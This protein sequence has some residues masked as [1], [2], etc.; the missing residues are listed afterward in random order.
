MTNNSFN[1]IT[2]FPKSG[3]TWMRFIIYELFFNNENEN[4][5]NSL[6]IKKYIPDLHTL[7]IQNNKVVLNNELINKK[8][9]LKS[10][11]SYNQMKN[12]PINKAI[13]IIRNPLNVFIS[14]YNYYELDNSKLDELVDYFSLHHTLPLLKNFNF[15][16][17]SEHLE[18]W[19]N[20]SINYYLFKYSDLIN[21]FD[22]QIV[23]LCNFLNLKINDKKIQIIKRNT[24]FK[25]LK[26]IEIKE[27]ENNLDG[28]FSDNMRGKKSFFMNIGNN[29]NYSQFLNDSQIS[30]IKDSFNEKLKKYNL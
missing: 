15:P 9:F 25:N 27:R 30:K 29:S 10:H 1:I 12:F 23:S 2:S 11:F 8:I 28:F 13:I 16:S 19:V 4:N 24:S 20:S 7:K 14:L 17:W 5:N 22:N 6:N 26:N 3:N 21:D 18:S